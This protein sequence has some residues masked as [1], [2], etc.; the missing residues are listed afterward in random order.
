[1]W[2]SLNFGPRFLPKWKPFSR[3]SAAEK[4]RGDLGRHD[5]G[6][7]NSSG[8][9]VRI[10][11]LQWSF[12]EAIFIATNVV[13]FSWRKVRRIIG[14]HA[15]EDVGSSW[16]ADVVGHH[17]A[18]LDQVAPEQFLPCLPECAERIRQWVVSLEPNAPYFNYLGTQIH[19]FLDANWSACTCLSSKVATKENKAG[20]AR[21]NTFVQDYTRL[22]KIAQTHCCTDSLQCRSL[23]STWFAT[24]LITCGGS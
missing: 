14:P 23:A 22:W 15:V 20:M 24:F 9:P 21:K 19:K 16:T 4:L 18:R 7:R 12:S 3:G 11:Q 6:V 8:G 17:R 5:E 13:P 10:P 2:R 1:M